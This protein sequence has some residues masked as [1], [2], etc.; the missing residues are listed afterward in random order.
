M[1]KFVC[2]HG[3]FYQPPR[4]NPW[5]ESIELQDSAYPYHDWNERITAECYAP[6][7]H[8]R[9]LDGEGRI[10]RIVSNYV[11]MS[12]NFGPTLLSWLQDK[13]PAIYHT[14][15]DADAESRE[16]F[17]GHG[18]AIAQCYNHMIMPLANRRD[19]YTQVLWGIR[20][21]TFRF[22]RAPEG[23]WLPETAADYESL[24]VL[25]ELGIR[26]T[27]LSPFQ[28]KRV[29]PM[30]SDAWEDVDGGRVDPTRPYAVE[31]PSG[32]TIVVFFY[33]APVSKAVAFENLLANG[34]RLANRLMTGFSDR[35]ERDQL[36]HIATDGE[37]YGHHHRHGEM[38]LA[39]ALHVIESNQL[40][41]LT[42][43]GEYLDRHPPEYIA[44]IHAPSAWS[45]SHRV[46]RWRSNCGCNTGGHAGWN[47]EW[48]SPLREALDLLRDDLAPYYEIT[49]RRFLKD[50]WVARDNYIDVVL[51]RHSENIAR[52]F[53]QHAVRA[54]SEEDQVTT[55]RLLE[56]QRHAMLMYT[57]CGWF[58]DELSG[59]ETVQVIQ[60]AARAIQ[61]AKDL[62]HKNPEPAF[63][64]V[65][66]R[67]RSNIPEHQEG[68]YVYEHFVKPAITDREKV[69]AHYA[70]SSLFEDYPEHARIYA[71]TVD[72]EHRQVFTAGNVRLAV[73]RIKVLF[74]VTHSSDVL[75]YGVLHFGDHNVNCGVRYY[76]GPEEYACLLRD[77][78]Q[79]FSRSDVPEVIRVMDRHFGA[80]NYSLRSLFRDE[81]RKILAQI[82]NSTHEDLYT[83]YG[84]IAQRY[85]PL[86]RFLSDLHAPAP[87]GLSLA[88]EFVLNG[89]LLRQ[90]RSERVDAPQ[91][92]QILGQCRTDRVALDH[93]TLGYTVKQHLDRLSDL[94][95]E[96]PEDFECLT[97]FEEAAALTRELPMEIN[98][99]K[100]QNTYHNL[101][102]SVAPTV[103]SRADQGDQEALRWLGHFN[104]LGEHLGF[105][106]PFLPAAQRAAA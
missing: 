43:Y 46:E 29:R 49:A 106:V 24:D 48:R 57:S 87:K 15:L 25:A 1:N 61:L 41:H 9:L 105:R 77:M 27:I 94:F 31:L 34:E 32:R 91:V 10:D 96:R 47:Q 45:C 54:L 103:R 65:L 23:M 21:F 33:D 81:Q 26:F 16:R 44:E 36:V 58:F 8:A 22:G 104:S 53:E 62:L 55:L 76:Q 18:S 97:Q 13:E 6:N 60:Y 85:T 50:P 99:W 30:A 51:N 7:A 92:R 67:A 4:E 3:H 102:N 98:R 20:D 14:I 11:R 19:Q 78:E 93:E 83:T 63:L 28:A 95:A 52:F 38:A 101:L 68:R 66:G 73:G 5:L 70:I 72:Q 89:E 56:L 74:E 82:L 100:P 86:V 71:F 69:A 88:I 84:H 42:N 17:S 35:R 80:S 64:D 59:L 40:A 39:Y 90:F 79:A 37:S 75:S 12:F 2:I